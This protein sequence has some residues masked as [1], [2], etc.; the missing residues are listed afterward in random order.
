MNDCQPERH[1]KSKIVAVSTLGSDNNKTTQ[2]KQLRTNSMTN[3]IVTKKESDDSVLNFE[4][5]KPN[6]NIYQLNDD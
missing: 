5:N 3:I 2:F 6:S 4:K 1:T